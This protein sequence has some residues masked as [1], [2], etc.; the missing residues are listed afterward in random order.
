[1]KNKMELSIGVAVGSA[2]QILLFVIPLCVVS[3]GQYTHTYTTVTPRVAGCSLA[4]QRP[5][6]RVSPTTY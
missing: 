3:R 4:R 5:S 2:T 6:P 1:M